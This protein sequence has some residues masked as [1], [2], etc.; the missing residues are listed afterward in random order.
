MPSTCRPS[1]ASAPS[2]RPRLGALGLLGLLALVGCG[3]DDEDGVTEGDLLDTLDTGDT[4]ADGSGDATE[5]GSGDATEDGSGDATEDGSGDAAD[6]SSDDVDVPL[7][8]GC[9][10][11]LFPAE[12]DDTTALQTAF[13]EVGEGETL[14]LAPGRYEVSSELSLAVNNVTLRGSG[15]DYSVLDFTGQTV[16]GN[17][18]KI[19]SDG[20]TLED[21]QVLDPPADGIRADAVDDITFRRIRV[22]WPDENSTRNGAYG[23]YPVGSNGVLIQDS[24]VIGARDAGIYVGQSQD[25]LVEGSKAWGNV[26]GI[27]IE[28]CDNAEVRN[29]HAYDNAGGILVFNLPGLSRYG[30]ATNVHNNL[31][32]NNNRDNFGIEGTVVAVVPPGTGMIVLANDNNE[33][34]NNTI[35]GNN[36]VGVLLF[37]YQPGIF[38]AHNDRNY[39]QFTTGNYIHDNTFSNNGTAPR[40]ALPAVLPN[41][42]R[43]VPDILWDGCYD[44]AQDPPKLNCMQDNEGADFIDVDFCGNFE[45]PST[46]MTPFDCSY[47]PLPIR[48]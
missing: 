30:S 16:G 13:I 6:D 25:V 17:G 8:E 4:A 44:P 31:I 20:V 22:L 11:T 7:P 21:F 9:D 32:E 36:T 48:P 19:T 41:L 14:C 39:N 15:M 33:I 42:P 37:T 2:L 40:G 10:R 23:L 34:H 38:G 43:P 26:A 12:G 47:E 18:V 28:N 29:N 45:A 5:D 24:E 27:E 1:T 35:R 3:K 46:D